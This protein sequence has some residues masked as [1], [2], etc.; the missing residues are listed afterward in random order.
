[1]GLIVGVNN[2]KKGEKLTGILTGR[3]FMRECEK[4]KC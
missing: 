2:P 4:L 3:Y 1:M